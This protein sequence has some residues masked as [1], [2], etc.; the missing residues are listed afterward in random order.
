[1]AGRFPAVEQFNSQIENSLLIH[2]PLGIVS[3]ACEISALSLSAL[4]PGMFFFFP[5]NAFC[6]SGL[7]DNRLQ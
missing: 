5:A 3:V 2:V 1:M 4:F 7:S 6:H